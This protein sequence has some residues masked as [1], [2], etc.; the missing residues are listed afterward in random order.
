MHFI[1]KQQINTKNNQIDNAIVNQLFQFNPNIGKSFEEVCQD[2]LN[3]R[4]TDYCGA[5]ELMRHD[6]LKKECF[7]G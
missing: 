7:K 6:K 3:K 1:N 5:Y 4:N 2:I